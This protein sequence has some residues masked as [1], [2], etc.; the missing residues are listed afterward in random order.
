MYTRVGT[1]L[2]VLILAIKTTWFFVMYHILLGNRHA[3]A[4]K[5]PRVKIFRLPRGFR[6]KP[7][8]LT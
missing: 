5:I 7:E 4:V 8:K 2:L 1:I 6:T 3:L